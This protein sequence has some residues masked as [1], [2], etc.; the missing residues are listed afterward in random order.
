MSPKRDGNLAL[1][2]TFNDDRR[3]PGAVGFAGT[4]SNE[5]IARNVG[6]TSARV[7]CVLSE[8]ND[9]CQNN[10]KGK[11]P[12]LPCYESLLFSKWQFGTGMLAH[13]TPR[14]RVD[15]PRYVI[16][17]KIALLT[18]RRPGS[19]EKDRIIIGAMVIDRVGEVTE[20]PSS[21]TI[22][23]DPRRSFRAPDNAM[24]RYWDFKDGQVGWYE[25]LYRYVD[26][27]E[28]S[29]YLK[30][31]RSKVVGKALRSVIDEQLDCVE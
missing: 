28:V 18:T 12:H 15:V 13:N 3:N 20:W 16:P 31:V 1:K 10:F 22:V 25:H 9:Y 7:W 19:E 24:L 14:E 6:G 21:T 5:N 8:C 30:A 27:N 4:C 26:D 2:C 29:A 23:G 11:A 17:G